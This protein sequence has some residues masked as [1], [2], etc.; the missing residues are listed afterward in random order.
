MDETVKCRGVGILDH[1]RHDHAFASNCANDRDFARSASTNMPALADV[2]VFFLAA[3]VSF[4]NLDLAGERDVTFHCGA[5]PM[6]DVPA[7][8]PIGARVF[9]EHHAPDLQRANALLCS[10]HQEA[11]FEPQLERYLG[12]LKDR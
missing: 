12:V 3:D 4:V 10:E 8:T 2:F 7:S 6:A 9:A 1:F 5:P 11:D